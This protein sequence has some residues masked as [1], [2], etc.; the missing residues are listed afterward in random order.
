M[1]C[2]GVSHR[3]NTTGSLSCRHFKVALKQDA[4]TVFPPHLAEVLDTV[5][6]RIELEDAWCHG[7]LW[8]PLALEATTAA[9]AGSRASLAALEED[10]GLDDDAFS[11]SISIAMPL[12]VF[13]RSVA[14]STCEW[15]RFK[16]RMSGRVQLHCSLLQGL[17]LHGRTALESTRCVHGRREPPSLN[18]CCQ[19]ELT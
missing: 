10:L 1:Q 16:Y 8:E 5:M 14:T 6:L 17:T 9:A 19:H 4:A 15:V 13:F 2:A 11:R 12:K 3:A 7:A 18:A